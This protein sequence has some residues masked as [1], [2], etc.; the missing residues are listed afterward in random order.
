M[1]AAAA[2]SRL[3]RLV[4]LLDTGST[5]SIRATA[6]RQL[7]QIAALRVRG[8]GGSSSGGG[9]GGV[10][11][12][13][14]GG[15]ERGGSSI[16]AAE[17]KKSDDDDEE[18]GNMPLDEGGSSRVTNAPGFP[19][20]SAFRGT[21]GDWDQAIFLMTRVLPHLRSKTWDTRVAAGQAIEAVCSASGLWDPDVVGALNTA[22]STTSAKLDSDLL[23]FTTF[24]ISQVLATGKKLLSSAGNEYDQPTF[25][26]VEER[27]AHAKQDMQRLG[28]SSM[29][30]EDI[31]FGVDVEKELMDSSSSL[32]DPSAPPPLP[33][34]RFAPHPKL[35]TSALPPPRFV[36][37]PL[38]LSTS[39]VDPKRATSSTASKAESSRSPSLPHTP[40]APSTPGGEEVDVS[41]MSARERNRLKR[42]RKMEEKSTVSTTPNA[43]MPESNAPKT[44]VID[45]QPSASPAP[46]LKVKMPAG[47][48]ESISGTP[49][50]LT[51]GVSSIAKRKET[52][53]SGSVTPSAPL[54]D[55]SGNTGFGGIAASAAATSNSLIAQQDQWPFSLVCALLLSDLFSP[56]W[57]IRHGAALGLRELFKT[58]GWGGGKAIGMKSGSSSNDVMIKKEEDDCNEEATIDDNHERHTR[59]CEDA[60]IRLLCVLSLD[61]LGDFVFD[62]VIAPVRETAGQTMASLL[63]WMP[64][65]SVLKVHKVLLEMVKQDFLLEAD[66]LAEEGDDEKINPKSTSS[67]QLRA[68]RGV[69]G[70]AWEV[71]HAGL[72]GLKY[73]V[74]VRKD[75]LLSQGNE[76]SPM[77]EGVVDLAIVCLRDDDDDVRGVAAATLLPIIDELV[78]Y[79]PHVIPTLMEQL[80]DCLGDLKDDLSS[81]TGGIMDLLSHAVASPA[82]FS[83]L[84]DG[85]NKSVSSLIPRLF[86]FFRHTITSVRLSVLNALRTFLNTP[87]LPKSSWV[88]DRMLRLLF[89]NLVVEE[90]ESIREASR[91]TWQDML[92]VLIEG[93]DQRGDDGHYFVKISKPYLKSFF[94]ILMTPL[95]SPIDFSLFYVASSSSTN[96]DKHNIDK[97]IL[98]QDVALVGVDSVIRGRLGAARALGSI[99]AQWL[100]GG[101]QVDATDSIFEDLILQ[102]LHSSSALQKCLAAVVVQEWAQA[103]ALKKVGDGP[104]EGSMTRKIALRLIS[105][106]ES[107][108]PDTYAEMVVMLQRILNQ[109]QGLYNTFQKEAKIPKKSIPTLPTMVDPL[110]ESKDAF[111]IDLAKSGVGRKYDSLMELISEKHKSAVKGVLEDR[112][113]KLITDIG[114]YQSI[115]EKQDVQ[116][117]A[118]VAGAAISLQSLPTKLNPIIRSIM[119][120]VKFEENYDLQQRSARAVADFIA[121]CSQPSSSS[122]ASNPSEKIVKNLCAFVCQDTTQTELFDGKKDRLEGILSMNDVPSQVHIGRGR[123][124]SNTLVDDP[125]LSAEVQRG[126]LIRRGAEL[127]LQAIS[128]RFG[129]QLMEVVPSLWSCM[130]APLLALVDVATVDDEASVKA[131][132]E[133]QGQAIIDCCTLLEVNLKYLDAE[134]TN[135]SLRLVEP[136]S[137]AIRSPFAV[138]RS[139]ASKSLAAMADC[140]TEKV[141]VTIVEQIVPLLN[142]SHSNYNRQGSMETVANIVKVLDLRLLPYVIVL[143]VPILGRMSDVDDSVRKLA[144]YTFALLIKMVPLEA[145]LP[146]PPGFSKELL[147]KREEERR[148]LSQLLDGN[149]V[150][151]YD[152][153]VE[154]D[155][156]LRKYQQDGVSWMAFLAKFQLHG[157]LCDDMGLGK[158]LQSICILASKHHERDNQA[159]ITKEQEVATAAVTK[160][161]KY[162]SSPSLIV[163]PPTLTGH[164]CHEIK[165]YSNNLRPLLYAGHPLERN[166][167]QAQIDSHDCI[168]MSY[169][170]LRNDIETL[171]K[172]NWFYCILDEGHVIKNSKTKTTKAVKMIRASHRLLLSGT[173]IQNNVLELWSLFDFLMPGFLGNEGQFMERYGRPILASRDSKVTAKEHERA[174][175]ALEALHKQVLPFLLRR[176]KED[177]LDD[178][179]PK[180]IQDISCEMSDVQKQLY[181]H[182]IR[183]QDPERLEEDLGEQEGTGQGDTGAEKAGGEKK[184]HVFQ[185]LQYLRKLVCHPQLVFDA[186]K[187]EHRNIESKLIKKGGT[188]RNIENAPKLLALKQLLT[189]CGIGSPALEGSTLADEATVSQ[190]R[191]LIFCQQRQMI[192]LIEKDLFKAVMPNVSYMR[193]DG[194]VSTDRRFDMVQRFNSDPSIDVLLLTT[195]VGGLGLTLTG[196]DTVIFVEHD[197]NPMK[198]MQAM[199]RA[200][201]LGQKKVVNVYRLITKN[202]LEEKIMGLQRF[203]INVAESVV[204]QENKGLESMET[205]QILNLFDVDNGDAN[206]SSNGIGSTE[207]DGS[208]G[209]GGRKKGKGISQKALLASIEAMQDT[210]DDYADLKEWKG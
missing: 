89:Q 206:I 149:K 56:K 176:M 116:V 3:D 197:W 122:T 65:S 115:K 86:P 85:K 60:A 152:I 150:E 51:P 129:K 30:G 64:A 167:L 10:G 158:T 100:Q 34:P 78:H 94:T 120:S 146:D 208:A 188:L 23:S 157:I 117:G 38:P 33:T 121:M 103:A 18:Q 131:Q 96:R 79:L 124:R 43:S 137:K 42:K 172:W 186:N 70:Y 178:L 184:Q 166:Q 15:G 123:G 110:G 135:Q 151:K 83:H 177:V 209:A 196:A 50:P 164:W 111:T 192:D 105:I 27:L 107:P 199:D 155:A 169:E 76:A 187:A 74:T 170:T 106:L 57:E 84:L 91:A 66:Y 25:T 58:Q 143:I 19:S 119:N 46:D 68:R 202:T 72:L 198:D 98:N 165:Q 128:A 171:S 134:L 13:G 194:S 113:R 163:C 71:R 99:M 148:F 179:P 32:K 108:A 75:L 31:D 159:G 5:P 87:D 191:V 195:S 154:I 92:N 54:K 93:E 11:G 48:E 101:L 175:L 162:A 35:A 44:R 147:L 200:H 126:K 204:N 52:D 133:A 190:H 118:T 160:R 26:S 80:W 140:M 6:A 82:V 21:E 4:T 193:L 49:L 12:G 28:L 145:G 62:Q 153:P 144:T 2:Q 77:L 55:M 161:R 104:T 139:A 210:G 180:I 114:F 41:K 189:D 142:D 127:T 183:E 67:K 203:K 88:D 109:C 112:R 22:S 61:R 24:S 201:R 185:T 69:P 95:G 45:Q 1:A 97:G 182:F 59:W 63:K 17:A 173:P 39:E 168:V 8:S 73:E 102:Y 125:N 40:Q 37:S 29:A 16:N 156:Q 14:G 90:R 205:D 20:G 181:D 174:S 132:H 47:M 9:G 136:L 130:T 81:S 207:G 138:I 141:M 7:G 53:R 36:P